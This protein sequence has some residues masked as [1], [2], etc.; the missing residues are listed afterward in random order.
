MMSWTPRN[1]I[2]NSGTPSTNCQECCQLTVQLG[3]PETTL[4][5]VTPPPREYQMEPEFS[6]CPSC[7]AP[8]GWLRLWSQLQHGSVS[9]SVQTCFPPLHGADPKSTP[10][11]APTCKSLSQSLFPKKPNLGWKLFDLDSVME[12]ARGE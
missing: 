5:K 2:Q 9:P 12:E 8:V 7:R 4:P 3:F 6:G 1:L 11:Q 10:N